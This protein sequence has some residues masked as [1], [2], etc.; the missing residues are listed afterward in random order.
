[1]LRRAR[2]V[3]N[4]CLSGRG[5]YLDVKVEVAVVSNEVKQAGMRNDWRSRCFFESSKTEDTR[6]FSTIL[7]SP[8]V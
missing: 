1:M 8:V 7:Q 6:K 3:G 4:I 2:D 5:N